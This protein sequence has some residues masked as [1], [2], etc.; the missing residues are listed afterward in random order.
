M[1]TEN[2]PS[3]S[4]WVFSE[5][6]ERVKKSF[7]RRLRKIETNQGE[8]LKMKKILSSKIDSLSENNPD[9]LGTGVNEF[10]PENVAPTSGICEKDRK[11]QDKGLHMVTGVINEPSSS[12]NNNNNNSHP[13]SSSLPPSKAEVPRRIH[14][15]IVF[16]SQR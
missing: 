14:R 11:P 2:A 4:D 9:I 8:I 7:C 16:S 12:S 13:R 3:I 10:Q 6:S 5:I 1:R 15:E